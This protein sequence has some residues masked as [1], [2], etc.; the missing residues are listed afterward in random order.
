MSRRVDNNDPV[1][2]GRGLPMLDMFAFKVAVGIVVTIDGN[3]ISS[4]SQ[5]LSPGLALSGTAKGELLPIFLPF[6]RKYQ[7]S[8]SAQRRLQWQK[9]QTDDEQQSFAS[10][11]SSPPLLVNGNVRCN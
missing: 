1:P 2:P 9:Y 6:R 4:D 10:L 8:S 3:F 11:I 7:N 5:I